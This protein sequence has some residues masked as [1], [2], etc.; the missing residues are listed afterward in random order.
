MDDSTEQTPGQEP[1]GDSSP[2]ASARSGAF[3]TEPDE[4]TMPSTGFFPVVQPEEPAATEAPSPSDATTS[5]IPAADFPTEQHQSGGHHALPELGAHDPSVTA[6]LG[7]PVQQPGGSPFA[8]GHFPGAHFPGGNF[9]GGP[10]G[11]VPPVPQAP[12]Y[13]GAPRRH[14]WEIPLLVIVILVTVVIYGGALLLAMFGV[15]NEYLL[16]ALVVPVLLWLGRGLTWASPR[17]QGVQMTPTQFPEGYRMVREAAA[18]YG[19]REV[20]DAFVVIGNGQ[21]NAFA[22]GH[23]FR[24]FV[25]VYSDLFEI[26]GEARDPDALA[27][28]IGHEVGHIAAGHVSYWRQVGSFAMSYLPVI[29]AALS[30]SQEYTAD[31]YGYFNQ[32]AGTPGGMGVLGAGKYLG[33]EVDFDQLADRASTDKGFFTWLV[34]LTASHPVLTWRAAALRNRTKAGSLWFA[35]SGPTRGVGGG[36]VVPAGPVPTYTQQ[37]VLAPAPGQV[38]PAPFGPGPVHQV[39]TG[40]YGPTHVPADQPAP[41]QQPYPEGGYFAQRHA[42]QGD[43]STQAGKPEQPGQNENPP[44]GS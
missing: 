8:S 38:P 11:P 15:V 12:S 3:S 25:V 22:S 18:R 2:T 28:I 36:A 37:E 24:R 39:P 4:S 1:Q 32:P 40:P 14:P 10:G 21:I 31:N 5:A 34:N 41:A 16:L 13:A 17:V 29:G 7:A 30:R 6:G 27:Y 35:P 26:G 19:M 20:P 44:A 9:P 43:S 33:K 23:G 42:P